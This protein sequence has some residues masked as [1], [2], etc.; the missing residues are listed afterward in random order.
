MPSITKLISAAVVV[1]ACLWSADIEAQMP[2]IG[3]PSPKVGDVWKFR[4]FDLRTNIE[5]AAYAHEFVELLP[6]RLAFRPAGS[7]AAGQVF[8]LGRDLSPCRRMSAS[9]PRICAER[10]QF[11]LRI[12]NR[13]TIDRMPFANGR[14][15][16]QFTC[17]VQAQEKVIVPAGT[18]E[19]V[20]IECDGF[21]NTRS[22]TWADSS[23]ALETL[24]YSPQVNHFVKIT[25]TNWSG[26]AG[27]N[28]R[29]AHTQTELIEF[30]PK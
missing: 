30:V 10:M 8:H 2:E 20:R 23:R 9:E 27:R 21:W 12:G 13:V 11:P 28:S 29:N 5:E 19:A 1:A 26:L 6:D 16:H 24:W 17:E 15:Y 18:F 22:G 3:Q 25:Y 7:G 4:R 14:G